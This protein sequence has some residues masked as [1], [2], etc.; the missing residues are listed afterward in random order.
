MT[1]AVRHNSIVCTHDNGDGVRHPSNLVIHKAHT[2][3][4]RLT[5]ERADI[6]D[7]IACLVE[8][9]LV[10]VPALNSEV[11]HLNVDL[12]AEN[13]RLIADRAALELVLTDALREGR[14]TL[15][16]AVPESSQRVKTTV[17]PDGRVVNRRLIPYPTAELPVSIEWD[18]P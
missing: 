14:V 10:D 11:G 15:S 18:E 6:P 5:I 4:E 17:G 13:A 3:S 9:G 2:F 12:I 16:I 7:L 1:T 8:L